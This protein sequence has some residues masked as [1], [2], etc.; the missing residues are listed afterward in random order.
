MAE[1]DFAPVTDSVTVA[2]TRGNRFQH[3]FAITAGNTAATMVIESTPANVAAIADLINQI[4]ALAEVAVFKAWK[5][6]GD[7]PAMDV[8]MLVIEDGG[9]EVE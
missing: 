4:K 8:R 7:N 1:P 2:R 6:T 3:K 9:E 5:A